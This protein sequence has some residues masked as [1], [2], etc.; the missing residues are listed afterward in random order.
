MNKFKDYLPITILNFAL[1][2]LYLNEYIK[3]KYGKFNPDGIRFLVYYFPFALLFIIMI[4]YYKINKK[5]TNALLSLIALCLHFL[6]VSNKG[7][8]IPFMGLLV[9]IVLILIG[10]IIPFLQ[11]SKKGTRP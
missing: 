5:N 8:V 2:L 11:K 9:S 6:V 10:F 3:L 1:G 7:R 4:I